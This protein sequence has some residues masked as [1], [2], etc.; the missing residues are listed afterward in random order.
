M[1]RDV[2]LERPIIVHDCSGHP[3]QAQ[4]S[5]WLASQDLRT[6]HLHSPTVHTPKGSLTSV[7]GGPPCLE[8]ARW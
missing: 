3:F 6:V 1:V 4:L 8:F 2:G 5:R 7:P